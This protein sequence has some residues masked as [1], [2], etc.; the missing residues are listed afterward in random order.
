MDAGTGKQDAVYQTIRRR[1]LEGHL[2]AGTHLVPR[3]LATE[4]GVSTTPVREAIRRLEAE[5]WVHTRPNMG[6]IVGEADLKS[7]QESIEYLAVLEGY[8]TAQSARFLSPDDISQ[9]RR[10]NNEMRGR[11]ESGDVL[12]MSDTNRA[13]HDVFYKRCPNQYLAQQAQVLQVRLNAVH[14][15]LVSQLWRLEVADEHDALL[16]LIERQASPEEIESLARRHRLSAAD[17]RIRVI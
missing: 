6:T 7:W 2:P 1:I 9:L 11:I 8:L 15:S 4:F 16:D 17:S 12:S 14:S 3:Q 10:L 5:G 13:F